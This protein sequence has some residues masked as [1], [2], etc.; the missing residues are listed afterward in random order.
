MGDMN[1]NQRKKKLHNVSIDGEHVTLGLK[2]SFQPDGLF[3][4]DGKPLPMPAE[5]YINRVLHHIL[6]ELKEYR[7]EYVERQ[8][9]SDILGTSLPVDEVIGYLLSAAADSLEKEDM[10]GLAV[11]MYRLGASV[12]EINYLDVVA[13]KSVQLSHL[14]NAKELAKIRKKEILEA[15]AGAIKTWMTK[16]VAAKPYA[17]LDDRITRL[18][19][20]SDDAADKSANDAAL[21]YDLGSRTLREMCAKAEAQ[22]KSERAMND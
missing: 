16:D 20:G 22:A 3:D 18:R 6:A 11:T 7:G 5:E 17:S 10:V 9:L 14:N 15:K 8:L 12:A 13:E 4:S 21:S 19:D 2:I 1:T